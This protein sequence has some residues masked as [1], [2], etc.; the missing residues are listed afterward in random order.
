MEYDL[1]RFSFN[2]FQSFAQSLALHVL[3][4]G[5]EVFGSGADGGR[6]A[7]FT[8][9][10]NYPSSEAP[11]D[12]YTVIQAK[13]KEKL[14]NDARDADW[15][16]EQIKR[17]QEKWAKASNRK[18]PDF[19]ILISNVSLS[20]MP[21]TVTRKAVPKRGGAAKVD[22]AFDTFKKALKTK[23]C[24][25]WAA[26]KI[27]RLLDMSPD[28]L[29]SSYALWITPN[30]LLWRILQEREGPDFARVIAR[31]AAQDLRENKF[32][33]LQEAGHTSAENTS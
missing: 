29:K 15:L 28:S 10:A 30:E 24:H 27:Y 21:V 1:T 33:R 23:D 11:W 7:A 26:E 32:T 14:T 22:A 12:G 4:P 19:Y 20:P 3:G 25:V 31:A 2:S 13:F 5:L 9:R 18:R 8:G 16:V 6:D 17:E